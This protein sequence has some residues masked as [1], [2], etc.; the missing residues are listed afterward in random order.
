[1]TTPIK[2]NDV[3]YKISVEQRKIKE[4]MIGCCLIAIIQ[5][6]IIDVPSCTSY[7]V[8]M[9]LM[10]VHAPL[11]PLSERKVIQDF[12]HLYLKDMLIPHFFP[13]IIISSLQLQNLPMLY[14]NSRDYT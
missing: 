5:D 13:L 9:N 8:L 11:Y 10:K 1:M 14:S 12:V 4:D 2:H 7:Y 6:I 3:P